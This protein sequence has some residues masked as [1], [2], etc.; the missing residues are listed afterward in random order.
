MRTLFPGYTNPFIGVGEHHRRQRKMLNPVFSIAHLREMSLLILTP[1]YFLFTL[2]SIP[3]P[4]FY[5]VTHNVT[6]L[7]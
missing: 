4:I 6:P 7:L 5:N 1:H 2:N 3:V